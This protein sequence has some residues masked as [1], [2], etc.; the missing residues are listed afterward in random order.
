MLL[1]V[2]LFLI[3]MGV[4]EKF[5]KYVSNLGDVCVLLCVMFLDPEFFPKL[6]LDFNIIILKKVFVGELG[7]TTTLKTYPKRYYEST[8]IIWIIYMVSM[9]LYGRTFSNR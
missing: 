8:D 1:K 2:N 9:H 7:C 4:L 3:W 5:Y 6:T